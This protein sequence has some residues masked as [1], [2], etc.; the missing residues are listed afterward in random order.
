M[1]T[2][3]EVSGNAHLV[4]SEWKKKTGLTS[5]EFIDRVINAVIMRKKASLYDSLEDPRQI[6]RKQLSG[7][8][9][10]KNYRDRCA[11]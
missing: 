6:R 11:T 4:I 3:M 9:I 2:T 7:V 8:K 1:S 10:R 5:V